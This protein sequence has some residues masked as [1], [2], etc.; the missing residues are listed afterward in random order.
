M[1]GWIAFLGGTSA[2]LLWMSRAQPFPEIGGRWAWLMLIIAGIL[3]ISMNSP[4]VMN[5]NLPAIIAAA[6]GGVG[7][8]VGAL[9]DRRNLD[10]ILTPFAGIL[11]IKQINGSY[12]FWPRS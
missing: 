7:M 12:S 10:V 4:R 9:Q 6:M 2:M 11:T 3:A 1:L 8:I 5:P